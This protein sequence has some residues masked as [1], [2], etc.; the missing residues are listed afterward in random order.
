ML[1]M[2][3]LMHTLLPEPVRARDEPVRH[4]GEVRD[5]RLAIHILAEGER[6]FGLGGLKILRFQ[7]F[8]QRHHLLARI[9]DL[10]AHGVFAGNRRENVDAFRQRRAGNVA[11]VGRDF[12]HADAARRIHL[13]ARDRRAFGDVA[14]GHRDAEFARASR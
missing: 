5:D 1:A 3:E 2:I 4:R 9:R 13:V 14:R 10:D 7:Q 11:F 6:D 8:A 12:I